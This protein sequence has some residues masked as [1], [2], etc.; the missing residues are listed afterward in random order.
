M[1]KKKQENAR[2]RFAH[3]F[4]ELAAPPNYEFQSHT[5]TTNRNQTK[6]KPIR[7]ESHRLKPRRLPIRIEHQV[8][9]AV[10]QLGQLGHEP[11]ARRRSGPHRH[12]ITA[13]L[14]WGKPMQCASAAQWAQ[15]KPNRCL[16]PIK[17]N[18]I[19]NQFVTVLSGFS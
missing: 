4:S 5:T 2:L 1:K 11:T 16:S 12:S 7:V 3:L 9:Q 10:G 19:C 6:V 13:T 14:L 18:A 8:A 15:A 17:I